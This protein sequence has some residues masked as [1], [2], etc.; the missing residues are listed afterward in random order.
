MKFIPILV[1]AL[2]GS[3]AS[4]AFADPPEGAVT[5]AVSQSQGA[6]ATLGFLQLLSI[7]AGPRSRGAVDHPASDETRAK[8]P[9]EVA[10]YCGITA[11]GA[12]F[13]GV[14]Q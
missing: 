5:V 7:L 8:P 11:D 14:A 2:V 13:T 9:T 6:A 12:G 4:T 3:L 1:I 10:G